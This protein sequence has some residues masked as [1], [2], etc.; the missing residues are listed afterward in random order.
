MHYV[1]LNTFDFNYGGEQTQA[2]C[3]I[4]ANGPHT[5]DSYFRV[6][7]KWNKKPSDGRGISDYPNPNPVLSSPSSVELIDISVI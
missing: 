6:S 5:G 4:R 3:V 2:K 1:H 7:S